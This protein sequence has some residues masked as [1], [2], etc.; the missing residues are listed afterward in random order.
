MWSYF[1]SVGIQMLMLPP[2][3]VIWHAAKGANYGTMQYAE[4]VFKKPS[5]KW[6]CSK[7]AL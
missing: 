1:V 3:L 7:C 4:D 5:Q 2:I 6:L